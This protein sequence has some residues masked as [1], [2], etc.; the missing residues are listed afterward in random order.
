MNTLFLARLTL[1]NHH[2]VIMYLHIEFIPVQSYV[3]ITELWNTKY[4]QFY[5]LHFTFIDYSILYF[6]FLCDIRKATDKA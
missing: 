5:I 3:K 6:K 4:Y 2:A 1:Q